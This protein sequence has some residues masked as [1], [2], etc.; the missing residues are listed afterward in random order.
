MLGSYLVG[1]IDQLQL[2]ARR[3]IGGIP[4]NLPRE[5]AALDQ[6]CRAQINSIISDLTTLA[7]DSSDNEPGRQAIRL[8]SFRRLVA[9]LDLLESTGVMALMRRHSDEGFLNRIVDRIRAEIRYPLAAPVVSSLSQQYFQIKSELNLMFVPLLEGDFLLHLPDLYHELA[10][11][12]LSVT[13]DPAIEPFQN[14]FYRS[15]ERVIEHLAQLERSEDRRHG[16]KAYGLL[17][18]RWVE[19]WIPF[20]LTEFFC[21]AFAATTVGPAYVWAHLHLVAKRGDDP[22]EIWDTARSHPPDEARMRIMLGCLEQCGSGDSAK[23]I[24][25]HWCDFVREVGLKAQPEYYRCVPDDLLSA[26]ALDAKAGVEGL[27]CRVAGP[28][29]LDEIHHILNSA[30]KQ[31]WLAPNSYVEWERSAIDRLRLSESYPRS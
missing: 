14:A 22:F 25:T 13:N 10:H 8:R 30:W 31:F 15:S 7:E 19:A 6:A 1:S 23:Q 24:R 3:L 5:Y 21:D 16:P 28:D 26:I 2:R 18:K 17:L 27:G 9:D 20:W 12:L 11:P 29:T 4:R